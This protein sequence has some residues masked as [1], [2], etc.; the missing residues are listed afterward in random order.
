[1]HLV[2]FF[3][4]TFFYFILLTKNTLNVGTGSGARVF[5]VFLFSLFSVHVSNRASFTHL[6]SVPPVVRV[7]LII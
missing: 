2:I 3:K 4:Y 7:L 1:M 6:L 5:F